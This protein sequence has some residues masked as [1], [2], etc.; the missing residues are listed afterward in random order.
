MGLAATVKAIAHVYYP[1]SGTSQMQALLELTRVMPLLKSGVSSQPWVMMEI[2]DKSKGWCIQA[3]EGTL[4]SSSN[5]ARLIHYLPPFYECLGFPIAPRESR[6]C[7]RR[8]S[9]FS[10]GTSSSGPRLRLYA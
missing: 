10:S 4:M 5:G 9:I 6:S 1:P 3:L 7:V 2:E 8:L